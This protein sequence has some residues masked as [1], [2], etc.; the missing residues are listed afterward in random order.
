MRFF[1]KIILGTC[2]CL[3]FIF[4]TVQL[5]FPDFWNVGNALS[6]SRVVVSHAESKSVPRIAVAFSQEPLSLEPTSL[7]P[8]IRSRLLQIYEPLVQFDRYYQMTPLLA[9]GFGRLNDLEWEFT[10]RSSVKFHNGKILDSSDVLASFQRAK[11]FSSSD[12]KNI[13]AGFDMEAVDASTLRVLTD[14]PD[15]LF[16]SK[17]TQLL[18]F[19]KEYADQGVFTPVGTGPYRFVEWK[20]GQQMTFNRFADYWGAAPV[21]ETA[22]LKTIVN[23]FDRVRAYTSGDVQVLASV[24]PANAEELERLHYPVF[25]SPSLESNF[26]IFR[27]LGNGSVFHDRRLREAVVKALNPQDFLLFVNGFGRLTNQFLPNDVQGFDPH[28]SSL[29]F[30][31]A[32]ARQAV[33]L[34]SPIDLIPLRIGFLK[35]FEQVGDYVA[36]RLSEIGFSV[37][38]S[39]FEP[40]DF[41]QKVHDVDMYFYTWKFDFA[42]PVDF[43]ETVIFSKG[44]ENFGSYA[45]SDV[46]SLILRLRKTFDQD[47]KNR[48]VQALIKHLASDDLYGV[49]LFETFSLVAAS[50]KVS[51]APRM[52]G[53]F[54]L[55]ELR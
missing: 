50:S 51:F 6:D 23:K 13:F 40:S 2:F 37:T 29:S 41:S 16:L 43:F 31:T 1:W 5:L 9:R 14:R 15:P 20:R 28:F 7:D 53:L 12:L 30:D 33:R 48:L 36:Q 42:D 27:S 19:P 11:N 25:S 45:N 21:Y 22:I 38:L 39:Y 4:V 52:D 49:S 10:L 46:D 24:P 35:G 18:I 44:S 54:L 47:E 26:F 8:A 32:A 3:A 34:V 17:M 55:Q